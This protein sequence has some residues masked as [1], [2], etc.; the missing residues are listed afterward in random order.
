M[1]SYIDLRRWLGGLRIYP[2][3]WHVMDE[4]H[5]FCDCCLPFV[6]LSTLFWYL[7]GTVN[8]GFLTVFTFGFKIIHRSRE[9][10]LGFLVVWGDGIDIIKCRIAIRVI[11]FYLPIDVSHSSFPHKHFLSHRK[12]LRGSFLHIHLIIVLPSIFTSWSGWWLGLLRTLRVHVVRC[13]LKLSLRL[14]V[15]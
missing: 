4:C 9:N 14:N 1:P 8:I 10:T 2:F 5:L 11:I 15:P 6:R 12:I 7:D 13:R 3:G